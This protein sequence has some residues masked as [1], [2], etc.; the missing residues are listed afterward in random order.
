[1]SSG[2]G[3][4][5][6][7]G[8]RT[9][10]T[11]TAEPVA[12]AEPSV[13]TSAAEVNSGT[14][15]LPTGKNIRLAMAGAT[16]AGGRRTPPFVIER[17]RE[18]LEAIKSDAMALS[19]ALRANVR[20]QGSLPTD[21]IYWPI[22]WKNCE[23]LFHHTDETGQALFTTFYFTPNFRVFNPLAQYELSRF[24]LL[25]LDTNMLA[26]GQLM[27]GLPEE[28]L[29]ELKGQI[30]GVIVITSLFIAMLKSYQLTID[31][32]DGRLA[33][34]A[35]IDTMGAQVHGQLAELSKLSMML[36]QPTKASRFLPILEPSFIAAFDAPPHD[37]E[38]FMNGVYFKREYVELLAQ[39][40]QAR[41]AM[42]ESSG[43]TRH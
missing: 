9:S 35:M 22:R 26:H 34:Q 38:K 16:M 32:M 7:F 42:T 10:D 13:V 23:Q 24:F 25:V 8:R 18:T 21:L 11:E 1:M 41:K 5:R 3:I 31:M 39:D 27:F 4:T 43:M 6:P 17:L 40:A 28:S 2:R 36:F 33:G 12:A 15:G 20:H 19:A 30:D 37:G 29:E 14:I